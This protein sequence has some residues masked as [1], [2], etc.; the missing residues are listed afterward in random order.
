MRWDKMGERTFV[1]SSWRGAPAFVDLLSIRQV[2]DT[3]NE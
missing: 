3:L 2:N 1:I